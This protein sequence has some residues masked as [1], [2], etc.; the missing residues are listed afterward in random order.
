MK[1]L[2]LEFN[3]NSSGIFLDLSLVPNIEKLEI[4]CYEDTNSYIMICAR[5]GT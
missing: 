5:G 4:T 1:E 2:K 3:V